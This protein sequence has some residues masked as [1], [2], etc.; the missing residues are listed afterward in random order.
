MLERLP[1]NPPRY[2]FVWFSILCLRERRTDK[3]PLCSAKI[4]VAGCDR[5]YLSGEFPEP[6][7]WSS[8]SS[9]MIYSWHRLVPRLKIRRQGWRQRI[10]FPPLAP[11]P[12]HS[13]ESVLHPTAYCARTVRKRGQHRLCRISRPVAE[14]EEQQRG[15]N[16]ISQNFYI[17]RDRA[18]VLASF[19]IDC[20]R[21]QSSSFPTLH[22]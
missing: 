9:H 12:C 16:F 22:Y 5:A 21:L 2:S 10:W 11:F 3:Q 4:A 13:S 15:P 7:M 17:R 14:V 1:A 19:V 8:V 18:T 20:D 6:Q